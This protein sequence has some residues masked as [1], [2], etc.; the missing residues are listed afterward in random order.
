VTRL[1]RRWARAAL[2]VA[3]ILGPAGGARAEAPGVVRVGEVTSAPTEAPVLKGRHLRLVSGKPVQRVAVGDADIAAVE[4]ITDREVLVLGKEAGTTSV[5]LWFHDRASESLTLHVR[6]DLALLAA[7]LREIHPSI[8]VEAAPD[9]DAV[10]LRGVVPDVTVS[11]AAEAAARAYLA[12]ARA[13][14]AAAPLVQAVAAPPPPPPPAGEAPPPDA[15][16]PTVAEPRGPGRRPPAPGAGGEVAVINLLRLERLPPAA[17][18]RVRAAIAPLGGGGVS[19]RR[20]VRGTTPSDEHDV[21]VLEGTVASQVVLTRV[22]TVAARLFAG[23]EA[24]GEIQ[25][26]ADEAGAIAGAAPTGARSTLT[27]S[28]GT[29]GALASVGVSRAGLGNRVAQNVARARVLSAAQGRVLSFIEVSDV[30]QVRVGIKLVEINRSRLLT[31]APELFGAASN[32]ARPT[33]APALEATLRPARRLGERG[34]TELLGA[35]A[36]VGGAFATQ[37]QLVAGKM[38]I[39]LLFSVLESEGI[40]RTLSA[41]S[42]T[43]LSGEVAEFQVGGEVPINTSILVPGLVSGT[44]GTV[45][46]PGTAGVFNAVEFRPFGI[47]L[48]VRPLVGDDDVITLDLLPEI[49]NPDPELTIAIRESTGTEQATTAFQTRSLRTTAQLPDGQVLVVGG[50]L[51]R[52]LNRRDGATPLL[53]DVPLLRYL[54]RS[55]SDADDGTEL[56][57]LVNPTLVRAPVPGAALWAFPSPSEL[58]GR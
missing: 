7:A 37:G 16:T 14:G 34:G 23:V 55:Y 53:R 41:P 12:S 24:R 44:P 4:V 57:L 36:F 27:R 47:Q 50:L 51:S 3:C 33:L 1:A 45:P 39:D 52:T 43:V 10:V 17:E 2:L 46:G 21:L 8:A 20:I 30:P 19:V 15:P 48:S 26:I 9:R 38:A 22:L 58:G 54:F 42:L 6:R 28:L 49:V 32:A 5:I 40:A 13:A 56:V 25:V 29:A 11:R 31:Y 35:L 18:E